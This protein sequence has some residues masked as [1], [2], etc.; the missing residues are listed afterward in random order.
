MAGTDF[1]VVVVGA[2]LAGLH[3]AATLENVGS[4]VLVLEAQRRVGGRIH[5]MRQHG[6]T[7]E[8]GG[9]YIGAGYERVIAAA[10]RHGVELMDVTPILEFFREQDLALDG[11][12]IRQ[13]E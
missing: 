2:G 3:A 12:I 11:E 10:Q 13:D 1:D 8:A 7:A 6:G 9:T 4:R 5:S